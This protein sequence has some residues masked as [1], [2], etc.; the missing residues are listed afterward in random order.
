VNPLKTPQLRERIQAESLA[1]DVAHAFYLALVALADVDGNPTK[2]VRSLMDRL[3][4]VCWEPDDVPAEQEAL[5]PVAELFLTACLYVA[6]AN[7]HYSVAQARHISRLATG[8]G[9]SARQLSDLESLV[10]GELA[11]RGSVQE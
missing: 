11:V 10:L 1:S 6:V 9:F 7:G 3:I 4:Q 2:E 8:L 5:W